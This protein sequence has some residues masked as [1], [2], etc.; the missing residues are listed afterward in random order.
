[1]ARPS[2][3]MCYLALGVLYIHSSPLWTDIDMVN[4]IKWTTGNIFS[5]QTPPKSYHFQK[6][7]SWFGFNW[8]CSNVS[9]RNVTPECE[10]VISTENEWT[11][12]KTNWFALQ[13][14]TVGCITGMMTHHI[15]NS[16]SEYGSFCSLIF[17]SRLFYV[18]HVWIF[19]FSISE[20]KY[21][22]GVNL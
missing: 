22:V 17:D 13:M 16:I 11:N 8:I 5:I 20:N 12:K 2:I 9:E 18:S 7:I 3:P 14:R 10:H 15:R 6:W 1:M 4:G 21:F 19:Y